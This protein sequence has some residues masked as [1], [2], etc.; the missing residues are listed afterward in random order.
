MKAEPLAV[1]SKQKS[2]IININILQYIKIKELNVCIAEK[3]IR[4]I[5]YTLV[6]SAF[7]ALLPTCG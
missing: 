6:A 2:V 4:F 1:M 3:I 5:D 7:A